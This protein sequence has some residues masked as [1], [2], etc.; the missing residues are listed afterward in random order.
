MAK[1]AVKK[2]NRSNRKLVG[3]FEGGSEAGFLI[4]H[5]PGNIA[6]QS[7]PSRVTSKS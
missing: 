3:I 4:L 6:L 1:I 7:N 5:Y 2:Q